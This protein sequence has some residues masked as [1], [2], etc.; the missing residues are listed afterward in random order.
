MT[1]SSPQ[2]QTKGR[3]DGHIMMQKQMTENQVEEQKANV[4]AMRA[5]VTVD[6]TQIGHK[7]LR[8]VSL[9]PSNFNPASHA[10]W[11]SSDPQEEPHLPTSA[12]PLYSLKGPQ[13]ARGFQ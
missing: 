5:D 1:D 8:Q 7:I 12:S 4:A 10:Y 9:N 2:G 3:T 6:T 13:A 11:L